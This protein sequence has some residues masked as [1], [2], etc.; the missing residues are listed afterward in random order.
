MR[1][2][3][4]LQ[5]MATATTANHRDVPQRPARLHRIAGAGTAERHSGK[6]HPLQ[7]ALDQR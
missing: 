5:S 4:V 7:H 1:Q 6:T 2:R 3:T